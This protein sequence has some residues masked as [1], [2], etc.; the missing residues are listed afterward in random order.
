MI[1]LWHSWICPYCMRVRAALAE[2]GIPYRSREIGPGEKPP[3]FQLLHRVGSV[4]VL[5]DDGKPIAD[6]LAILEHLDRRFPE[7]PL[8]PD[9]PGRAAVKS[10]YD[11]VNHLLAQAV[12][13]VVR[14]KGEARERALEEVRR[15]L[16]EFDIVVGDGEFLAGAFSAADLA[17]ASFVTRLPAEVRPAALELGSLARWERAV[18][19][20]PAVRDQMGPRVSAVA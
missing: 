15:A 16:L 9:P 19:G 5:V 1:E 2:K 3:E 18:L 10:S 17:L 20:R 6:S 7:P 4:P 12:P 14:G 11:R 8:F 13:Q